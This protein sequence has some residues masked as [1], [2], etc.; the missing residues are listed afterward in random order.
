MPSAF[1]CWSSWRI[2]GFSTAVP[3]HHQRTMGFA[4][5]GGLVKPD[6]RDSIGDGAGKADAAMMRH[7]AVRIRGCGNLEDK[8]VITVDYSGGLSGAVSATGASG[9]GGGRPEA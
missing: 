5:A 4:S 6:L 2:S 9:T 7:A 3:N 1:I 8:R